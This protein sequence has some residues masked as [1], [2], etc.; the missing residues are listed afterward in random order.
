MVIWALWMLFLLLVVIGCKFCF[1][2]AGGEGKGA[3]DGLSSF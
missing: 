1:Y 3:C 2:G